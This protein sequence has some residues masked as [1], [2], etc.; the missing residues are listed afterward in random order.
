M[1]VMIHAN[2][3]PI[4]SPLV[5]VMQGDSNTMIIRYL[6][7]VMADGI[8]L[9]GLNW[10]IDITNSAG[11]SETIDPTVN[12][13]IGIIECDWRVGGIATSIDGITTFQLSGVNGDMVW[14]TFPAYLNVHKSMRTIASYTPAICGAGLC[15]DM[16]CGKE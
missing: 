8:D 15:G 4:H 10:Q 16:I 12:V 13:D 9:T 2:K 3:Q 7:P 1:I 6:V 5:D 11:E 14:Q